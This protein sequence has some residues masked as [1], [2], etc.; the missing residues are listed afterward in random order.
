V[1]EEPSPRAMPNNATPVLDYRTPDPK[2][3]HSP[4]SARGWAIFAGVMV[5][6]L[7]LVEGGGTVGPLAL[8]ICPIFAAIW[9]IT[10]RSPGGVSKRPWVRLQLVV[11]ALTLTFAT[12]FIFSRSGE[13]TAGPR[14]LA[15]W[16][17]INRG[18]RYNPLYALEPWPYVA[19]SLAWFI[20]VLIFARIA[21]RCA[22]DRRTTPTCAETVDPE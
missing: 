14:G 15:Y 18:Y 4:L 8:L 13:S 16:T 10:L 17:T 9:W 7:S 1:N 11:A 20:G 2:P 12:L 22:V 19:G 5:G 6:L 21:K 3:R